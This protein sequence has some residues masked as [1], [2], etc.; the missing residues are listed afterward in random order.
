MFAPGFHCQVLTDT[1]A[2][3]GA[4]LVEEGGWEHLIQRQELLSQIWPTRKSSLLAGSRRAFSVGESRHVVL[5]VTFVIPFL[6]VGGGYLSNEAST[7]S[8]GSAE[9]KRM[10]WTEDASL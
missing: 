9:R 8:A 4:T 6:E 5:P 2:K 1:L 3:S 7:A 10:S